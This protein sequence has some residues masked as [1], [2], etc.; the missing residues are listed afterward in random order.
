ME[1]G[2]DHILEVED[3]LIQARIFINPRT[4]MTAAPDAYMTCVDFGPLEKWTKERNFTPE[5]MQY[6]CEYWKSN[7]NVGP[8]LKIAATMIDF[9]GGL[10]DGL[11]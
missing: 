3:S 6:C 10:K 8:P 5:Q 4:K 11:H 1:F 9:W 7:V 2:Y